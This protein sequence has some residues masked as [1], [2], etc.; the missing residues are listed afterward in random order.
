M[1][2]VRAVGTGL[3]VMCVA[4]GPALGAPPNAAEESLLTAVLPTDLGFGVDRVAAMEA[5]ATSILAADA[6]TAP[7]DAPAESP[8]FSGGFLTG[9]EGFDDFVHPVSSPLYFHD[10]FIDTH[11]NA[12][13]LWHEFPAGS[14]LKG[15]DLSVWAIQAFIALTDR[16]QFTATSDGYSRIRARA[17][18]PDEGWNDL[19]V[20]LKY[21][22]FADVESQSIV[23]AGLSW[24]LSNGHAGTAHGNVDELNPY[25]TAAK[26]WGKFHMLGTVGGRLPMNKNR[27]N[28]V[29]YES[30]HF[31]YEVVENFFPLLELN[32]LHYL[33]NGNRLPL[34]V[35][36]LDFASLGSNDVEGNS[37]F[38]ASVGFRWKL[39][40]HIELGAT[41]AL[42]LSNP[43]NDI[44]A[45]RAIVSIII[46]L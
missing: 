22:V 21:N 3:F 42:P 32:G 23:S 29:V 30:L 18:R 37:T 28:Y 2:R 7:D 38:W 5:P 24:K 12:F 26:A 25:I 39:H 1:L 40:E 13:Y 46:G 15:G 11:I 41:Y 43:N 9:M 35:G 17:L 14:A 45:Q 36:G 8:M 27:G 33:S 10:P 44:L 34:G 4:V 19:A 31:D 20:G 16:L 6:A